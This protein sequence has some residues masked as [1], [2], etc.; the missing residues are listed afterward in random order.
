MTGVLLEK[1]LTVTRAMLWKI[2]HNNPDND[3]LAVKIGRYKKKIS[4]HLFNFSIMKTITILFLSVIVLQ[5]CK[6]ENIIRC[7]DIPKSDNMNG[8]YVIAFDDVF[9]TYPVFNQNNVDEILIYNTVLDNSEDELF[10]YNLKTNTKKVLFTGAIT[11]IPKWKNSEWIYL[12]MNGT[13]WKLHSETK[14]LLEVSNKNAYTFDVN[15]NADKIIYYNTN[16]I[17]IIDE[18]SNQ[19]DSINTYSNSIE[20][21]FNNK[22]MLKDYDNFILYDN[23][24]KKIEPL[25]QEKDV[26]FTS[27]MEWI[28]DTEFV[29]SN[30]EGIYKTNAETNI[31]TT[32]LTH[33]NSILYRHVDYSRTQNLLLWEKSITKKIDDNVLHIESYIVTMNIDGT[34][35]QILNIQYP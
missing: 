28:N 25:Y 35:E 5:S 26:M 2:K 31:T 6:K 30:K 17:A 13:I 1:P 20:W 32:I 27:K 11:A 16:H 34:N 18:N 9:L 14:E 23:Y 3:E 29:W 10:I 12:A 15:Y 21:G 22:I 19:I 8:G 33:C 7:K 4:L 24:L